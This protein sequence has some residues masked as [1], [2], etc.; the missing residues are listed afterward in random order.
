MNRGVFEGE[1]QLADQVLY[2][3]WKVVTEV[4]QNVSI[5]TERNKLSGMHCNKRLLLILFFLDD[6]EKVRGGRVC[7]AEVSC[8][9]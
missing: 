4:N 8:Y 7:A 3:N 6:F 1:L 9:H 2:G 5:R